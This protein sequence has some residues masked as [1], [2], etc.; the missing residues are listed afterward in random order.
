MADYTLYYWPIPFRGQFVRAV[1]AQVGASWNE[2][3]MENIIALKNLPPAKQPV[4]FVGPPVLIDHDT[5]LAL[6]Q[7]AAILSYLGNRHGLM[8]EDPAQIALTHKLIA[9][10]DDVLYEMTLHNGT[11]MWTA[12]RWTAFQPRLARWMTMFETLGQ[13]HGLQPDSGHMLGTTAPQ[14]ADLVTAT[15]WGVM[16]TQLPALRP[17]L[18]THAPSI[19]GLCDRIAA[20]PAQGGLW[21]DS[22]A[23]YGSEWCGGQ[24]EASLRRVL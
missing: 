7:T 23:A 2:P 9:D 11:E 21:R 3:P 5:G 18:E 8:P 4:P 22:V 6:S 17:V 19:A 1:L 10:A 14:L 24:I 15:L 16:T 13:H 12:D 20:L